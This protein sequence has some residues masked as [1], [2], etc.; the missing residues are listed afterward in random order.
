MTP[1]WI[2]YL[3]AFSLTVVVEYLIVQTILGW[4]H[5]KIVA[6]NAMLTNLA[7]HP[8]LCFLIFMAPSGSPKL[9]IFFV[10]EAIVPIVESLIALYVLRGC[11]FAWWRV[12]LAE[13]VAN[14]SSAA[15]GFAPLIRHF[16]AS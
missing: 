4:N 9:E 10:G 15:L 12:T 7:T 5:R 14:L 2:K 11:R 3:F 6:T 13:V 16:M 1:Y 8:F